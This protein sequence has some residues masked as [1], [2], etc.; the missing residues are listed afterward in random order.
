MGKL[1]IST[2][3]YWKIEKLQIGKFGKGKI[4]KWEN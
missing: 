2:L 4:K 1:E 3:E